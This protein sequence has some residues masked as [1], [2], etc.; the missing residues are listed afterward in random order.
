M[1]EAPSLFTAFLE[2][3]IRVATPLV[4]AATG[5]TIA[6]RSGVINLGIEGAMLAGALASAIGATSAG[7]WA[8]VL[9]AMV[10]GMALAALFAG[11][12][13]GVGADQIIAGT[14]MTLLATGLTGLGY[15]KTRN[16]LQQQDAA[17]ARR[18]RECGAT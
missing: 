3:S 18:S 6:E 17:T 13:V 8:G 14:A 15:R 12:V 1:S 11:I 10:A 5:E 2:A 16:K 7:P 9:L 4:L